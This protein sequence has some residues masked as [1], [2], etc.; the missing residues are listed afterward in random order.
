MTSIVERRF[1]P[2]I[3]QAL[4]SQGI[5]PILARILAARGIQSA[6][7]LDPSLANIIPPD[8]LTNTSKMAVMLA[9]AIE[10]KKS[11]LKLLYPYKFDH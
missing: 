6:D 11:L 7:A 2:N 8:Q 10:A 4:V 3:A 5:L 9:D 1:D